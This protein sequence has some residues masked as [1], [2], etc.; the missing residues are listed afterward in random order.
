MALTRISGPE[1]SGQVKILYHG[2]RQESY[3]RGQQ[4]ESRECVGYAAEI[5][6]ANNTDQKHDRDGEHLVGVNARN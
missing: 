2:G 4:Q 5:E 6:V 3:C 1:R